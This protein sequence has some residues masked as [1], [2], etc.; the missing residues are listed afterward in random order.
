M[1]KKRIEDI[2]AGEYV[3][4]LNEETGKLVFSKAKDLLDAS[5]KTIFEVKT[6]TGRAINATAEHPYL[7]KFYE[8]ELR[9]K[10]AGNVWN[11]EA[12]KFNSYCTRWVEVSQLKEGNDIAVPKAHVNYASPLP[13]KI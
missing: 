1:Q 13:N 12:D 5:N 6:A 9:D 8:Q 10:Y 2:K 3:Q 7:V 11:K 4:S